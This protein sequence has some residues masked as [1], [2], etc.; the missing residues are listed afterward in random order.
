[1]RIPLARQSR[2]GGG[3]DFEGGRA[4]AAEAEGSGYEPH[5]DEEMEIVEE[6]QPQLTSTLS[7]IQGLRV[8]LEQAQE[9][10]GEM[11]RRNFE[12][13]WAGSFF[14]AG[15]G[16]DRGDDC[17]DDCGD[18]GNTA[19]TAR[20]DA[21]G[22]GDDRDVSGRPERRDARAEKGVPD[23]GGWN[24]RRAGEV[25][26][27]KHFRGRGARGGGGDGGGNTGGKA[28]G[29]RDY[30]SG[31]PLRVNPTGKTYGLG[32]AKS[33]IPLSLLSELTTSPLCPRN[34]P[35]FAPRKSP[36]AHRRFWELNE[37]GS[38]TSGEDGSVESGSS[39]DGDPTTDDEYDFVRPHSTSGCDAATNY[40]I[41][42]LCMF[43]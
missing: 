31:T 37:G 13:D 19:R 18:G 32:V 41:Q 20:D 40:G 5:G 27:T 29:C 1:M 34:G 12:R 24:G 43:F 2:Q 21:S 3:S 42:K 22:R 16:G 15:T 9:E 39:D 35:L 11:Y 14:G 10:F 38:Q 25:S 17:G 7:V 8:A 28:G 26:A 4:E 6:L 23:D 30:F 36:L 33:G